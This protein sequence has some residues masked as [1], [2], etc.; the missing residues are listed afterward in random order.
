VWRVTEQWSRARAVLTR[1]ALEVHK[2]SNLAEPLLVSSLYTKHLECYLTSWSMHQGL[3]CQY[4]VG[5][6]YRI[7]VFKETETCISLLRVICSMRTRGQSFPE[8]I[9]I[10]GRAGDSLRTWRLRL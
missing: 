6:A 8:P 7:R 9:E 5:H 2:L 3:C 1:N 4:A 10:D